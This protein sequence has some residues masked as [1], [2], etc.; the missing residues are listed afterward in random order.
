M[1]QQPKWGPLCGPEQLTSLSP[2]AA[3]R[4]SCHTSVTSLSSASP[5]QAV[6]DNSLPHHISRQL[7]EKN[8]LPFIEL[9]SSFLE[10]MPIDPPFEASENNLSSGKEGSPAH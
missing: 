3:K 9:Q 2:D 5:E 10:V 6:T 1:T 8:V 4:S 7:A